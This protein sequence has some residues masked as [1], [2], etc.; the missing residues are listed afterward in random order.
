MLLGTD[1]GLRVVRTVQH[2]HSLLSRKPAKRK[3]VAC[4][5]MLS[6]LLDAHTTSQAVTTASLS[7]GDGWVEGGGR[8]RWVGDEAHAELFPIKS[9]VAT[10]CIP[11]RSHTPRARRDK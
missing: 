7:R 11:Y 9:D 8:R 5:P 2:R 4:D 6:P 1:K 10:C 3:L